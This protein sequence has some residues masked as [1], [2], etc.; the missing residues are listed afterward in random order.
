M[1]VIVRMARPCNSGAAQRH[2][3]ARSSH[4]SCLKFPALSS[5]D[6]PPIVGFTHLFLRLRLNRLSFPSGVS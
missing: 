4:F 2:A 6:S 3:R 1:P 5:H